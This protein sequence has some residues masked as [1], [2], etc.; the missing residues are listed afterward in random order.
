MR[1]LLAG[2][3]GTIGSALIPLLL[4][5]G[6]HVLALTR[7]APGAARLAALSVRPVRADI[8]NAEEL[9]A[10]LDGERA[11]AVIHQA[12]SITGVPFLHRHLHPTDALRER[13]TAHLLRAA[14]EL[15]ARRFLTQSFFLG[16]GYRDHG[17]QWL[18]ENHP[19]AVRTGHRGFDRHMDSLRANEEQV[20]TAAGI[21][22]I[23]LRYGMFYGPEPAT[24][25]LIDLVRRRRLPAPRP[26]GTVSLIHIHDA[27]T[28]TLAALHRGRSGRSYNIVDDQPV[29]FETYF[30][31]IARAVGAPPPPRVPGR[32]LAALPY[33][34]ALMVA[35]RIRLSNRRAVH[36]LAWAPRYPSCHDGL[37]ALIADTTGGL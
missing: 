20:F 31:A 8:M 13:G 32:L 14:A 18:D 1:I 28:A 24:H 25:R 23:A 16:Y 29:T 5:E 36:E 15:G 30:R 7:S 3:T 2:A 34:H 21:E 9:L 22:G 19:F 11:D 12:T 37:A 17:E 27:A 10:A 6:H 35:T 33:V 4:A 26:S